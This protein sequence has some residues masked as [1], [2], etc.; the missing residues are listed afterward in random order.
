MDFVDEK[1]VVPASEC[2]LL[3]GR[4]KRNRRFFQNKEGYVMSWIEDPFG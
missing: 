3:S 4:P 2:K 1:I